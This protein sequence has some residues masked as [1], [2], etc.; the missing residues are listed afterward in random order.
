MVLP[1][2]VSILCYGFLMCVLSSCVLPPPPAMQW[3]K[4]NV[5]DKNP[6]VHFYKESAALAAQVGPSSHISMIGVV[7]SNLTGEEEK[8][9]QEENTWFLVALESALMEQAKEA[10]HFVEGSALKPNQMK[11]GAL[12]SEVGAPVQWKQEKEESTAE[13]VAFI[14]E[15]QLDFLIRFDL[16]T[17]P[18]RVLFGED[19]NYQVS[20]I[21]LNTKGQR[22]ATFQMV[23]NEF[24]V[25]EQNGKPERW[26]MGADG[27]PMKTPKMKIDRKAYYNEVGRLVARNL[28]KV[29][30]PSMLHSEEMEIRY[31]DL[32]ANQMFKEGFPPLVPE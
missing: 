1:R 4:T 30:E 29:L 7:P 32:E 11:E 13:E 31:L 19:I 9:S 18:R 24:S 5:A 25:L 3:L 23:L 16:S 21:L 14:K 6:N 10:F 28:V 26:T 20:A 15:N 17:P 8:R 12:F 2:W 27:K 22:I